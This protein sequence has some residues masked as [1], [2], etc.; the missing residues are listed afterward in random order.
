[1]A[2]SGAQSCGPCPPCS[3]APPP[4]MWVRSIL[5]QG[6]CTPHLPMQVV[7]LRVHL[8]S[9]QDSPLSPHEGTFPGS[10]H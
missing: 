1:M 6:L 2:H 10:R 8:G 4:P 3:L 5:L 7:A 9:P